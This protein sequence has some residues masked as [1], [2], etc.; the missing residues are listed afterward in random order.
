M[1]VIDPLISCEYFVEIL[2]MKTDHMNKL[3]ALRLLQSIVNSFLCHHRKLFTVHSFLCHLLFGNHLVIMLQNHPDITLPGKCH[4]KN[5]VN[6]W[7]TMHRLQKANM[8]LSQP[9][10]AQPLSNLGYLRLGALNVHYYH[11]YH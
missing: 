8:Q 3:Q 4:V 5:S 11:D 2:S 7:S 6:T 9:L 1:A 10:T